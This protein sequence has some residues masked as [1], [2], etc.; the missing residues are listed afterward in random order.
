MQSGTSENKTN[1]KK[2]KKEQKNEDE[3]KETDLDPSG[4]RVPDRKNL[5]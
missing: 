4:K 1:Q 3:Q 2:K 5:P